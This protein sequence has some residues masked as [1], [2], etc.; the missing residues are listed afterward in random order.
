MNQKLRVVSL[1]QSRI[2]ISRGE[3]G[4]EQAFMAAVSEL[5]TF[6]HFSQSD[7]DR[8]FD[9]RRALGLDNPQL[10]P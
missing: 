8:A 3:E 6:G 1:H 10:E 2:A 7:L 5:V 4:G 9:Y